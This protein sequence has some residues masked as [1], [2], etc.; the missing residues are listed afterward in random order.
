V[1]VDTIV[2]G[3]GH[4]GLAA[5]ALLAKHG[6][7]VLVVERC[8]FVGGIAAGE[9]FHPGYRHTGLLHDSATVRPWVVKALGLADHGLALR[10]PPPL[11]GPEQE[12][13]G[14]V[15]HPDPKR[16]DLG[17]QV[18]S[19]RRYRAFL[20]VVRPFVAS[21]LD[22][23]APEVGEEAKLW[24]LLKRAMGLRRLGERDMLELLRVGPSCA[25][26]FVS[27]YFSDPVLRAMVVAPALW[28]AW[29]GPRSPSGTTNLLLQ[30][31][32]AGQEVVGGPAALVVALEKACLAGGV[33]LRTDS[34]VDRILVAEGAAQG[35]ELADRTTLY[36]PT[37]LSALGP[38]Q[39]LLWL[40]D[41]LHLPPLLEH[42]IHKVRVRGTVA[43]V[44]L[45]LSAPLSFAGRPDQV[46]EHIRIAE[47]PLDLERAFDDAKHRR[48]PSRPPPLDIR[49]PT[50]SE[51]SLAPDGH[52]VAS[53]LVHGVPHDLD[54]GWGS[55]E[56]DALFD[57]AMGSLER[58]VPDLRDRLMGHEVL[59]PAD[60]EARYAL[61]GAHP[62]H[63]EHALDQLWS[64]RP[65]PG[66]AQHRT[67]IAG[68]F[69]GSS[70]THP[71][72]GITCA[73]G[74]FAAKAVLG[75]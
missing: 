52:H 33:T 12:G 36:A 73:P 48:L 53:V 17:D 19:W 72:G 14:R 3:A 43:K 60:I 54:G 71:G 7:K 9:E 20:D 66:L 64:L 70:G 57:W 8:S 45:A 50:V 58:Y 62:F 26:D 75:S 16:A 25:D 42:Q 15:L 28:G 21:L 34:P 11:F 56:R 38:R 6:R 41:P 30:E 32:L 35:V 51:S 1:S 61:E 69:L 22:N 4:N 74:A 40:V 24:P 49:V 31:S 2:I 44:H 46:F 37:V 13:P 39:T 5:A 65:A 47:D 55:A 29:M 27:E 18:E 59:T 63:G 68:L 23:P 67:P 10:E